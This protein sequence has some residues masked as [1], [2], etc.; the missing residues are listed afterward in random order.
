MIPSQV[1]RYVGHKLCFDLVV[2]VTSHRI[3]TVSIDQPGQTKRIMH[4]AAFR[5]AGEIWCVP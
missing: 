5:V 2:M 3:I 1:E 4:D